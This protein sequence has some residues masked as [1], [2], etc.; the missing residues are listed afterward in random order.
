ML[1]RFDYQPIYLSELTT[2]SEEN[3]KNISFIFVSRDFEQLIPANNFLVLLRLSELWST[4]DTR[5][6]FFLRLDELILFLFCIVPKYGFWLKIY[7]SEKQ[8]QTKVSTPCHVF[9]FAAIVSD[10][11]RK[12]IQ[13]CLYW[14]TNFTGKFYVLLEV[15][16]VAFQF[17][18]FPQWN[19]QAAVEAIN[20]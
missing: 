10:R 13:R 1:V 7:K 20:P 17:L 9:S 8:T 4:H 16:S 19:C 6:R 18:I 15:W 14:I 12:H 5:W 2:E 11:G 3:T